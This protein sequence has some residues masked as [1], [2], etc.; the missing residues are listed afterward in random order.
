MNFPNFKPLNHTKNYLENVSSSIINNRVTQGPKCAELEDKIKRFLN[1]KYAIL[2]TSGTSA[3]MMAAIA[4]GVRPKDKVLCQNLAW[5][6]ATNPFLIMGANL[7]TVDTIIDSVSVD[8]DLLE[9]KIIK[10]KPKVLILVHLNG[11]ITS[12]N[13]INY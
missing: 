1:C 3:L 11:Q 8:I 4:S 13:K 6:A 7:T 9:K 10:L 12:S 2:T 5:V